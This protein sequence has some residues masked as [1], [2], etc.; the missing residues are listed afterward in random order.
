MHEL[1]IVHDF[2]SQRGRYCSLPAAQAKWLTASSARMQLGC[3]K[4]WIV[5]LMSCLSTH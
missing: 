1:G 5:V 2:V 4:R 3:S